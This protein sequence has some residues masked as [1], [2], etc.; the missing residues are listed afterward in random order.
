MP[1]G[2]P[3]SKRMRIS[4]SSCASR[5]WR[6]VEAAGGKFEHSLNLLPRY[7]KL[8]DD[9]LYARTRF[10]I[11]KNRSDGHPGIAKHPRAAASVRPLSTGWTLGPIEI[12]HF[13]ICSFIVTFTMVR[14]LHRRCNAPSVVALRAPR[15]LWPVVF[16][17]DALSSRQH[18]LMQNAGNQNAAGRLA[19]KDKVST[20]L[21]S[22]KFGT[23]I[24]THQAHCWVSASIWQHDSR[25]SM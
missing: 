5:S 11:L 23:N 25:S 15:A 4:Q 13:L 10:K 12:C 17:V 8:L 3:W 2:V 7:M 20:V 19:V 1:L 21:H 22:S 16:V 6:R 14:R 9:F 18:S 24:V